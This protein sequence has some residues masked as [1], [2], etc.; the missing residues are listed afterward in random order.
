MGSPGGG[1]VPVTQGE[2]RWMGLGTLR[3]TPTRDGQ[4]SQWTGVRACLGFLLYHIL[5][6]GAVG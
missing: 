4:V 1:P 2:P 5:T 6:P 3:G